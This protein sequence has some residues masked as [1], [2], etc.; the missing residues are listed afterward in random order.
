MLKEYQDQAAACA[1]ARKAEEAE[2]V[3]SVR[4]ELQ[5]DYEQATQ[6]LPILK[7]GLREY[8]AYAEEVEAIAN[9]YEEY[10]DVLRRFVTE[11]KQNFTAPEQIEEG[12][13]RYRTFSFQDVVFKDG[14]QVDVNRRAAFI[15][16]TRL[17][18]RSHDG[19]LS[20]LKSLQ[21]QADTFLKEWLSRR[22]SQATPAVAVMV[23]ADRQTSGP[24]VE[25]D[26]EV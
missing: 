9:E 12:I 25:K 2:A 21:G 4:R 3:E 17:L 18:L 16:T 7:K 15:T 5:A 10:P 24:P 26:F 6:Q 20:R 22:H 11:M 23:S 14:H 8:V 19:R 13:R 1:A